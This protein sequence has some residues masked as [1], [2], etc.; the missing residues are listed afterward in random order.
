[1]DLESAVRREFKT[2]KFPDNVPI[3]SYGAKQKGSYRKEIILEEESKGVVFTTY[4][5]L[6]SGDLSLCTILTWLGRDFKGVVCLKIVLSPACI[7]FMCKFVIGC[8]VLCTF[9]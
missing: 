4:S 5:A 9:L 6:R 2:I 3:L 8:L 7:L 1:L